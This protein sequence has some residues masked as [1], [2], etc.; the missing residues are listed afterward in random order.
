MLCSL[1]CL[2]RVWFDQGRVAATGRVTKG[3]GLLQLKSAIDA[4]LYDGLESR[5][6]WTAF[7]CPRAMAEA[8]ASECREGVWELQRVGEKSRRAN[9]GQLQTTLK[10]LLQRGEAG[11]KCRL[12]GWVATTV[13][14]A[15]SEWMHEA[16]G[17]SR[18]E[19]EVLRAE[20]DE[21]RGKGVR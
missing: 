8:G 2:T 1:K 13:G 18:E 16:E 21:R 4:H 19:E 10:M 3:C 15:G 20:R 5:G 6:R 11:W 14:E 9:S 17:F 7:D 12:F